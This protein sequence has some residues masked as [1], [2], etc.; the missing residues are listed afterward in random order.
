ME[1][2]IGNEIINKRKAKTVSWLSRKIE[3]I[4]VYY[5]YNDNFSKG[6]FVGLQ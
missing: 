5:R 6:G 2:L 3:Y 1:L 4:S